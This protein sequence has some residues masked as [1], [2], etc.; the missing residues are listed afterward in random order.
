MLIRNLAL[1]AIG[2]IMIMSSFSHN[3]FLLFLAGVFVVY[4]EVR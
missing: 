3:S 4:L 2:L 1:K